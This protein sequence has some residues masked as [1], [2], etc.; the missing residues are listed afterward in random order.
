MDL[1]VQIAGHGPAVLWIHG[2]TMD[3]TLWRPVWDLLPGFRHIGVDLPGHGGF[4]PLR[5][6]ETLPSLAARIATQA[7]ALRA[8]KVVA[9]SF[10]SCV[11]LENAAAEPRTDQLVL[12]RR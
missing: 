8:R 4:G 1:H 5:S 10:G 2:Y 12:A 11:A 9:L 3:S 7:R 6:D